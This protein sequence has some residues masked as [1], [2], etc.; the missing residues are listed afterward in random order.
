MVNQ[1]CRRH[2]RLYAIG[3]WRIRFISS[4]TTL[5]LGLLLTHQRNLL[6]LL[7][8]CPLSYLFEI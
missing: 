5:K 3:H 4:K 7:R 8:I 6:S 1:T 2:P